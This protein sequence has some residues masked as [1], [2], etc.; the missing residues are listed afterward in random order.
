MTF[1]A[2]FEEKFVFDIKPLPRGSQWTK[3]GDYSWV[4]SFAYDKVNKTVGPV[5]SSE[6]DTY[7]VFID[8]LSSPRDNMSALSDFAK[9]HPNLAKEEPYNWVVFESSEYGSDIS[10]SKEESPRAAKLIL[11]TIIS[12]LMLKITERENIAF[13]AKASELSRV[14]LYRRIA[15]TFAQLNNKAVIEQTFF[16][17]SVYFLIH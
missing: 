12:A 2:Y 14:K 13:N 6:Y 17:K 5:K 4:M 15:Q 9:K 1:K 7:T 16:D 11:D 8:K 10:S 3:V